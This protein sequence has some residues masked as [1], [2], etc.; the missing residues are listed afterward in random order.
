MG[1]FFVVPLLILISVKG[2]DFT[3]RTSY[4][5]CYCNLALFFSSSITLNFTKRTF[6]L[7]NNFTIF[8]EITSSF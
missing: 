7:K 4:G 8:E 1:P 6:L 5:H 2:D 3:G